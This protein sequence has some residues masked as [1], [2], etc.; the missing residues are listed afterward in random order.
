MSLTA[1]VTVTG[2]A[3]ARCARWR[4]VGVVQGVDGSSLALGKGAR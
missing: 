1:G 4:F 3:D 2:D